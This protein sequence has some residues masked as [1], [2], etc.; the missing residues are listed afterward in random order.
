MEYKIKRFSTWEKTKAGL[1][2]FGKGAL[3]GG[4]TG[5][6]VSFLGLPFAKGDKQ[7]AK[8]LLT[9]TGIGAVI[10]GYIGAKNSIKE[11]NYLEQLKNDPIAAAAEKEKIKKAIEIEL[12]KVPGI[13]VSNTINS[14]KKFET[15][16]VEKFKP[17]LFSYVKF[18]D[19]FLKSNCD[20]WY[21]AYENLIKLEN[22]DSF[23]YI[24][25]NPN[26]DF[27]SDYDRTDE[28]EQELEWDDG[29]R[30]IFQVAGSIENKIY[31]HLYYDFHSKTYSFA[32]GSGFD[33]NR[34]SDTLIDYTSRWIE[35][36][37][38]IDKNR[39]D[40]AEVAIIHNQ[41]INEFIRGLR[42]L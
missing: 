13:N 29:L 5:G 14:L 35:N 24:F 41:I 32:C 26:F 33:Y 21:K 12:N 2:G 8:I 19:K 20:K 38:S 28:Y 17:D 42:S 37:N 10:G 27:K 30:N 9:G 23:S 22:F 25:P 40:L 16:Y 18:Y 6:A 3:A 36:I 1:K 11:Y 39:P 4:A 34:L 31:S 7:F 15:K